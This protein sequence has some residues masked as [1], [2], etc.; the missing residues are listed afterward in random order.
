MNRF[1]LS[2]PCC[3]LVLLFMSIG[4][5]KQPAPPLRIG[6]NPW[7]GYE[8][9]YLAREKGYFAQEGVAVQLIEFESEA[10][11]RRAFERGQI[12][13][14]CCT[15]IEVLQARAQSKRSPQAVLVTDFS[16]GADVILSD[17]S[18]ENVQGL[19]GKR[20]AAELG[21]LNMFILARALD[22]NGLKIEDINYVAM[23]QV[24]ME[25]AIEKHQVDA[26]VTYPPVSTKLGR[27]K[28]YKQLFS[29]K[30][31]PGE[32][33]DILAIDADVVTH[34]KKD[35][36]GVIK[37]WDRA[38]RFAATNREEAYQIMAARGKITVQEM[39]E[40]FEGIRLPTLS[41]QYSFLKPGGILEQVLPK[42][43]DVLRRFG[44]LAGPKHLT[45][46]VTPGP[47]TLLKD[48]R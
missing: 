25:K 45:D 33:P 39:T 38:V 15:L 22:K 2:I 42:T 23:N 3:L 19:K 1:F 40:A 12:D 21:S 9:I 13:A 35:I 14:M 43:D 46:C 48:R 31:I 47:L 10:G 8:F 32:L 37:A 18:I 27:T 29:S 4:C 30:E 34:R 36:A 5:Q 17:T 24:D 6:T 7:P 44:Q 20:V 28:K 41:E 16:D 26:V 11:S